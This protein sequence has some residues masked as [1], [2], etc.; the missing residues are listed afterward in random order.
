M[1]DWTGNRSA[2]FAALGSSNHTKSEREQHDFYATDPKAL[3]ALAE[4]MQ[5]PHIIYECACG[6][7]HLAN[8][9]ERLGHKVIAIECNMSNDISDLERKKRY[10]TMQKARKFFNK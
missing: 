10:R 2:L 6:T 4:Q 9:L 8:E 3:T 1:K 5:L 7:G